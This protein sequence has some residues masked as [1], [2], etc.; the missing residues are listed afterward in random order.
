MDAADGLRLGPW[1]VGE[2]VRRC[3][4]L[5]TA[6]GSEHP[7]VM[8]ELA[9][10]HAMTG[11]FADARALNERARTAFIERI[12]VRRMQ[13]FLAQSTA[14][15]ELLAG[16]RGAAERELRVALDFANES[17]ERDHISQCAAR[18]A[19]VVR[20]NGRSEEA[21][22]YAS[23]STEAAPLD[24]AA[25]QALSKAAMARTASA[26]GDHG[27]ADRL[28]RAAVDVAPEEMPNLCAEVLGDRA[29]IL[30]VGG[31]AKAATETARE[32]ARLFSAKGNTEQSALLDEL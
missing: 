24:G 3:E 1:P 29:E 8:M 11:A 10:L 32:A 14:I 20:A 5:A 2:C 27:E 25:A 13:M 12:R 6:R 18:L 17:E 30:L 31:Q 7:G 21:A 23:L 26:A 16:D 4:G 19:S 22:R 9:M 28:S 15:V